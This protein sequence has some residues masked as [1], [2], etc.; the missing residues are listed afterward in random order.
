LQF[1]KKKLFCIILIK[2]LYY[3]GGLGCIAGTPGD[4]FKIRLINDIQGV[5][6]AGFIDCAK[7]TLAHDGLKG[8]LKGFEVNFLRA[9][10]IN[11]SELATYD[12]I[13]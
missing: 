1:F 2:K 4:I 6:Y 13:K 5:K 9:I 8:F 7:K 11:A 3:K 12:K 10:V